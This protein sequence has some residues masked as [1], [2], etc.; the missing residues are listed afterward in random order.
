MR[1]RRQMRT[2]YGVEGP[3]QTAPMSHGSHRYLTESTERSELATL[4]FKCYSKS[5]K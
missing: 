4:N 1:T 2:G 3:L 5:Y